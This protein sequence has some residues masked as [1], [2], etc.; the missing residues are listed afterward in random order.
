[1]H[2]ADIPVLMWRK[3]SFSEAGNC[4]EVADRRGLVF[5]RDTKLSARSSVLTFPPL[6]WREF[7]DSVNKGLL[8]G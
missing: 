2:K 7:I 3:S 8:S 4:V 6:V 1:V 5:V